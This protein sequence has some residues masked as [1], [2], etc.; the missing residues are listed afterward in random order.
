MLFRDTVKISTCPVKT[1]Y[2]KKVFVIK[3]FKKSVTLDDFGN[4]AV[5]SLLYFKERKHSKTN[6]L[7]LPNDH[8]IAMVIITGEL[9]L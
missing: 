3:T 2:K 5:M 9:I 6:K 7:I 1:F 8:L 4:G